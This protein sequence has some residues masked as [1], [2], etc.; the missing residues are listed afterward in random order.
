VLQEADLVVEQVLFHDLAVLAVRDRAEL[1]L[2]RLPDRLVHLAGTGDT[3]ADTSADCWLLLVALDHGRGTDLRR[4]RVLAE[5]AARV[6]LTK[7]V[8][9]LIELD[10]DCFETK[11]IGIRQLF[12]PVQA[13]L[14]VHQIADLPEDR[15]IRH[16]LRHVSPHRPT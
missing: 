1:Q 3:D 11:L 14:L 15:F 9:T 4:V 10:L 16:R 5:L 12:P 7:Q 8:P 13:L 2:E 6:S